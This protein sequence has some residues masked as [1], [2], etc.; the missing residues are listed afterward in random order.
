M[1]R[2]GTHFVL[3]LMNGENKWNCPNKLYQLLFQLKTNYY[4]DLDV[5]MEIRI[6]SVSRSRAVD[7]SLYSVS[8]V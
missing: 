7:R 1:M 8:T 4:E 5:L 6:T 2:N 3:E